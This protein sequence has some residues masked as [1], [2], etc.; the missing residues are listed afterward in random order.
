M[1]Q[2]KIIRSSSSRTL[3]T[4]NVVDDDIAV[5][6]RYYKYKEFCIEL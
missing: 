3:E 4:H 5:S 6:K 2:Y 1:W